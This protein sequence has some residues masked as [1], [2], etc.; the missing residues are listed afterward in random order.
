M[1]GAHPCASVSPAVCY[2]VALTGP[3][4]QGQGAVTVLTPGG[5]EAWGRP[6]AFTRCPWDWSLQPGSLGGVS[7]QSLE[8]ER[9]PSTSLGCGQRGDSTLP[10]VHHS[11]LWGSH[12]P[13]GQAHLWGPQVKPTSP[14]WGA[15]SFLPAARHTRGGQPISTVPW[16]FR[17]SLRV[18][19]AV[20]CSF[21]VTQSCPTL[22]PHGLQH[23]RPPCPPLSPG[24]CSNSCPLSQ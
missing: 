23:A 6:P 21:A 4:G 9:V 2:G 22:R 10:A 5:R 8:D 1:T 14:V 3:C 11:V 18:T 12:E 13:Q 24:V 15:A 19:V 17:F 16:R 20:C 7:S